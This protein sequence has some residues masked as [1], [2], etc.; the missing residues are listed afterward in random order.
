VLR[1]HPD[2]LLAVALGHPVLGLDALAR[3]DARLEGVDERRTLGGRSSGSWLQSIVERGSWTIRRRGRAIF[4]SHDQRTPPPPPPC[5]KDVSSFPSPTESAPSSFPTPRETPSPPSSSMSSPP[6]I[7]HPRRRPRGPR[8]RPQ[9]CRVQHLLRRRLVRRVHR[10]RHPR[11]GPGVLLRLL[12]RDPRDD[13]RPQVRP[14]PR[15]GARRRRRA[16]RHCRQ[17]LLLP[18]LNARP[19]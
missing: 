2:E 11:R 14:H 5:P 3:G 10:G 12:A 13:P 7:H 4:P 18:T 8:D 19:S 1:H 9:E 17:R 16:R 6:T 15:A